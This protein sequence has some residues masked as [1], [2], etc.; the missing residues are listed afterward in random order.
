[1]TT[2][3]LTSLP[4]SPSSADLRGPSTDNHR[5]RARRRKYDAFQ[6]VHEGQL[7]HPHYISGIDGVPS[8][9]CIFPADLSQAKVAT[10]TK[11]DLWVEAQ[12]QGPPRYHRSHRWEKLGWDGWKGKGRGRGNLEIDG[13]E[14]A[15]EQIGEEWEARMDAWYE[16][17]K[18]WEM[19]GPDGEVEED[20][21]WGEARRE[22]NFGVLVD[23]A[24]ADWEEKR[25]R[26]AEKA[27][28]DV[29]SE[30]GS[31]ESDEIEG[32]WGLFWDESD[33]EIV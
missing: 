22:G 11:C 12:H 25:M 5:A 17:M 27:G 28:W 30:V 16:E 33:F 3:T 15:R 31:V 18:M 1:M 2:D 8:I 32:G 26:E 10:M 14:E 13:W 23:W 19:S 24:K 21:E 7:G 6:N 29:M 20:S 9:F 4:S